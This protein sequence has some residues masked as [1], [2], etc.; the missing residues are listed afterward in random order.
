MCYLIEVR[1]FEVSFCVSFP[2]YEATDSEA[3]NIRSLIDDLKAIKPETLSDEER[4]ALDNTIRELLPKEDEPAPV[5]PTPAETI[6]EVEPEIERQLD[7]LLAEL[8][9]E[10]QT[11]K[12]K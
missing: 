7:E 3:R 4:Q 9:K 12:R 6:T 2:A 1:L 5:E 8:K 10:N 11:W